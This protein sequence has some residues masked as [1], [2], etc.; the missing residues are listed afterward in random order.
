MEYYFHANFNRALRK[1]RLDFG[2]AIV[3]P[4]SVRLSTNIFIHTRARAN[5]EISRVR[6]TP[7][8]S[9]N[10]YRFFVFRLRPGRRKRRRS[11]SRQIAVG[12]IGFQLRSLLRNIQEPGDH[13]VRTHVLFGMSGAQFR[14]QFPLS[15]VLDLVTARE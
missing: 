11:K 1:N 7:T 13:A 4:L 10:V 15:P 6:R 3:V 12:R 5:T 2:H 14:L 8:K 9:E